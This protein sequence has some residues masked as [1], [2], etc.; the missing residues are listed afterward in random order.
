[1]SALAPTASSPRR[2]SSAGRKAAREQLDFGDV[3]EVDPFEAQALAAGSPPRCE[4]GDRR[5]V[6]RATV[7]G[8]EVVL[9]RDTVGQ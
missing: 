8:A 6:G 5:V 9:D 7:A 4:R 1:M 2:I 3:A